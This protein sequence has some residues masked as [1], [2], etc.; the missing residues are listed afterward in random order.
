MDNITKSSALILIGIIAI[1][2]VCLLVVKPTNAQTATSTQHPPIIINP[3]GSVS[4]STAPIQRIESTFILT[5][6]IVGGFIIKR[7][8]SIING[9]G[10][11]ISGWGNGF[12]NI[13]LFQ[14]KNVTVENFTLI[15]LQTSVILTYS[16]DCK[17]LGNSIK[18]SISGSQNMNGA[19]YLEHS[20]SNMIAKNSLSNNVNATCFVSSTD[21]MIFANDIRGS[22]SVACLLY[23][24][25]NNTF[26]YNNFVNNLLQVLDIREANYPFV[27]PK[28][29]DTWD[30]GTIGNYW[31]DYN[32]QGSY[33]INE[34]NI[35][36]HPLPNQVDISL[37]DVGETPKIS[38]P[39]PSPTALSS[40]SPIP[41]INT[42]QHPPTQPFPTLT[43]LV[44]ALITIA[45]GIAFALLLHRHRKTANL[46][47]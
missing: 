9:N 14:V 27:V 16:Q 24:S 8:D 7:N 45:V 30:N 22:S 38:S 17:I 5:D 29:I 1:S 43:V 23:D 46:S 40:N 26:Y 19:I 12:G 28:S 2:T 25:S 41:T 37:T 4:P 39:K 18:N 13:N 6:N 34:N 44:I 20:S 21:N 3:D 15:N 47:N 35:D 31:S 32:G 11:T 10:H 42:G 33:D 36:N